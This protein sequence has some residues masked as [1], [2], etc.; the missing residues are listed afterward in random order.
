MYLMYMNEYTEAVFRHT[1]REHQIPLKMAVS[2]HVVAGKG[3][4][5]LW[6]GSQCLFLTPEPSLPS[7]QLLFLYL[8]G[9]RTQGRYWALPH[10]SPINQENA[11]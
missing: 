8:Q 2:H 9:P 5:D 4:R 3:T 10:Q 6:K 11:R 1:R 7:H